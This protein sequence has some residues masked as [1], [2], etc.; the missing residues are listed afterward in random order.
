[1]TDFHPSALVREL[2]DL[3]LIKPGGTYLDLTLGDGGHSEAILNRLGETG[4]VI[5]VDWD[6]GSIRR[7]QARLGH[8]KNM[9]FIQENFASL[10]KV[11]ER[12]EVKGTDGIVLDLGLS[13]SQIREE[14]RG[15]SFDQ[16]SPLDMRMDPEA[17]LTA[18][19]IINDWKVEELADLFHEFGEERQAR[20][21]AS[22]IDRARQAKRIETSKELGQVISR[23]KRGRKGRIHP[24]TRCFQALRIAVNNELGNL[25]DVLKKGTRVLNP[26]GRICVMSFHSLED[27]IVK[28]HFL[29]EEKGCRCAPEAE[30]C[31]CGRGAVLKVLTRKPVRPSQ[32]EIKENPRCRSAKLRAA[33]RFGESGD[34]GRTIR[35]G[36]RLGRKAQSA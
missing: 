34:S 25:R 10:E 36:Y 8:R 23:A 21:I 24:A 1:V 26:G 33:K 16:E 9:V 30:A 12:A 7:A 18:D 20:R 3:L 17:D 2:Q 27:R 22:H 6:P 32:D 5:G 15:F 4:K 13:L 28:R 19:R 11:L 31:S 35:E 14:E 29:A